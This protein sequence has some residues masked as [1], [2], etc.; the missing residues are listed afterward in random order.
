MNWLHTEHILRL[1]ES[2]KN[3][4]FAFFPKIKVSTKKSQKL[5]NYWSW[6]NGV[7]FL[8]WQQAPH[9]QSIF[10]KSV[11][12]T[13][14]SVH[15]PKEQQKGKESQISFF[16]I[17]F[18]WF[19]FFNWQLNTND[20]LYTKNQSINN[21]IWKK[22][23]SVKTKALFKAGKGDMKGRPGLHSTQGIIALKDLFVQLDRLYF[24]KFKKKWWICTTWPIPR[25]QTIHW[26][27]TK[28]KKKSFLAHLF[29]KQQRNLR[30]SKHNL[31][32]KK[33]LFQLFYLNKILNYFKM[34]NFYVT[35]NAT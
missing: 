16:G 22:Q 10:F 14:F 30:G 23:K 9:R 13:L 21:S 3:F 26:F 2:K 24:V 20:C 18:Q 25:K 11:S 33:L 4:F 7:W 34:E 19:C 1:R 5:F 12:I 28:K 35:V 31:E 8:G 6:G 32:P 15:R 17:H 27:S 29:Q